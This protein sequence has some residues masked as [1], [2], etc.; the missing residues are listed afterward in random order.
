MGGVFLFESKLAVIL[1]LG[2]LALQLF[3][4]QAALTLDH[5]LALFYWIRLCAANIFLLEI[6]SPFLPA[7]RM[8][9]EI[10]L[11]LLLRLFSFKGLLVPAL[12]TTFLLLIKAANRFLNLQA[13]PCRKELHFQS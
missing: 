6:I 7:M 8:A 12:P 4:K 9:E 13:F 3:L 5:Q 2:S 10:C 11:T 1:S